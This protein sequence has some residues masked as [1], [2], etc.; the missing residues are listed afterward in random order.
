[1]FRRSTN[2]IIFE[3]PFVVKGDKYRISAL[4]DKGGIIFI[5]FLYEVL[6][7]TGTDNVRVWIDDNFYGHLPCFNAGVG[8][9]ILSGFLVINKKI[10]E[11]IYIDSSLNDINPSKYG[12]FSSA[13]FFEL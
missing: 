13:C 10:G 8:A 3:I 12:L 5:N 1:M 2:T 7:V 4:D 11:K 6:A 9:T